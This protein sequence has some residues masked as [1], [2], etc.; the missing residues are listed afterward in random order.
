MF[1]IRGS[2]ER[3]ELVNALFILNWLLLW[4]VETRDGS[5]FHVT[6]TAMNVAKLHPYRHQGLVVGR[7]SP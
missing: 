1:A 4:D 7:E 3:P 2:E 5:S 6:Y